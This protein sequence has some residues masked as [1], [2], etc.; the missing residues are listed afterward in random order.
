MSIQ[1][2]IQLGAHFAINDRKT[3]PRPRVG[4]L[5]QHRS[6]GRRIEAAIS[7]EFVTEV[8]QRELRRG[9]RGA[10]VLATASGRSAK[11]RSI[12]TASLMKR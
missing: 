8:L 5:A 12:A 1:L 10:R 4:L 6:H 3:A 11:I 2:P 9:P 7:G